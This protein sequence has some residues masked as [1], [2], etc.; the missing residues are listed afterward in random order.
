MGCKDFF[1]SLRGELA[2]ALNMIPC[3]LPP[4]PV[5]AYIG[6]GANQGDP[7]GQCQE[8]IGRV[9]ALAGVSWTRASSF[10][11]SEPHLLPHQEE[12]GEFYI[13]AVLEVHT[14][15]SPQEL[16]SE[17]LQIEQAL[18]R[19][20]EEK[21]KWRARPID[22]DVLAYDDL[23]VSTSTLTIPHP[24]ISQRRFVLLPW[25][26][27]APQWRHPLSGETIEDLLNRTGDDKKVERL[28][29]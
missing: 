8:A 10:Y 28:C 22:L 15:L 19:R 18:G 13:N 24:R 29:F 9:R 27:L 3:R 17:L 23:V 6:L 5:L 1:F 4:A 25:A 11:R 7:L 14:V 16:F 2:T 26:E 20:F 12:N 21:G